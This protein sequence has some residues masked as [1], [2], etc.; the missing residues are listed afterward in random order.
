VTE[1]GISLSAD[2]DYNEQRVAATEQRIVRML[3]FLC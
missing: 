3:A 1:I 2:S